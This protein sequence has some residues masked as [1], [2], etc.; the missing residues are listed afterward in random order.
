[1]FICCFFVALLFLVTASF[2]E[3]IQKNLQF[4]LPFR[5]TCLKACFWVSLTVLCPNQMKKIIEIVLFL[6]FFTCDAQNMEQVNEQVSNLQHT[7]F[8]RQF[9]RVLLKAYQTRTK[10]G[11]E[12]L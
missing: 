4:T 6:T 8:R 2:E 3:I 7:F 5:N 12:A 10:R 1:M 9:V 11:L